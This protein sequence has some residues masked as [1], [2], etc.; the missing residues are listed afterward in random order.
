MPLL[1][2][3]DRNTYRIDR[4]IAGGPTTDAVYLAYHTIFQGPCVQK[5]VHVH[6]LEDALASN[7]PAF[8]NRLQHPH[9][10][11]VREA[12]WCPHQPGAIIFVMPLYEGGSID[13]ALRED[14]RF[15]V[16]QAV[17][18]AVHTLD[19]LSYVLRE[20]DAVHRDVKPG[21]VVLDARRQTAYLS[22]F[23]SAA[24]LDGERLA[25]AVAG[26]DHYRPPEAKS[27]G[28][29]GHAADLFGLG[30]TLFEMLNGRL[31]WEAHDFVKVEA[32]LISGRRALAD[33]VL[34]TYA[35]HVST[36]MRRVTKKAIAR[37]CDD[38]YARAEDLIRA[39]NKA[40]LRC[41]DWR[42]SEGADL[43]G[44]WTGAWPPTLP[45]SSR[46]D[47]RLRAACSPADPPAGSSAWRPTTGG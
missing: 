44:T 37:R 28:R 20:H 3:A 6:G 32:R 21:N 18:L 30:M 23:G 4:Q 2:E 38:R 8:L 19:A 11:E 42:H 34:D 12:Q 7:E 33:D 5:R 47:Y 22:D 46:V 35:P 27:L 31:P 14:Y 15:S 1:G 40:K 26:T 36:P 45:A 29:V 24:R 13:A 16:H 9:I 10:V 41:L 25:A 17:D 43:E 39:L